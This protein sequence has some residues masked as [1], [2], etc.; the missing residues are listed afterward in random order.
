MECLKS[1]QVSMRPLSDHGQTHPRQK[2]TKPELT[3]VAVTQGEGRAPNRCLTLL[4]VG[5]PPSPARERWI[6][7]VVGSTGAGARVGADGQDG[8]KDPSG[9][10]PR[11]GPTVNAPVKPAELCVQLYVNYTSMS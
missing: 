10:R 2:C 8:C 1:E 5:R 11:S 3:D 9:G 7:D 4:G 6:S